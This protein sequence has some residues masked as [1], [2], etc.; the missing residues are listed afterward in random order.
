[1]KSKY[2]VFLLFVFSQSVFFNFSNAATI[3][4]NSTADELNENGNCTFREAVEAANTNQAVDGCSSGDSGLDTINFDSSITGSTITLTLSVVAPPVAHILTTDDLKIEGD[5][6]ITSG[7]ATFIRV[8]IAGN[9]NNPTALELRTVSIDGRVSVNGNLT[10]NG[11]LVT[12]GVENHSS[13][14]GF[15][16]SV[17][18]STVG[19]LGWQH[20]GAISIV[21]ST[22][23]GASSNRLSTAG[24]E[25]GPNTA[26]STIGMITM[27]N[28]I[29]RDHEGIGLSIANAEGPVSIRNSQLL[30]NSRGGL[31]LVNSAAEI[32]NL[33]VE[34]NESMANG[35]AGGISLIN[36]PANQIVALRN[37]QIIGNSINDIA[38]ASGIF[39]NGVAGTVVIENTTIDGNQAPVSSGNPG[40]SAI[41]VV[42]TFKMSGSAVSNNVGGGLT[43]SSPQTVVIENNTFSGNTG[44]AIIG[45][46]AGIGIGLRVDQ[47]SDCTVRNNTIAF[48]I[49]SVGAVISCNPTLLLAN[50]IF[51]NNDLDENTTTFDLNSGPYSGGFNLIGAVQQPDF[52]LTT[53]LLG[54]NADLLPLTNAGGPTL[55]HPL[56]NLSLAINAGDNNLAA[57]LATDQRG[58]GFPRIQQNRVDIGAFETAPANTPL[59]LIGLEVTQVI[60]DWNNSIPLVAAKPTFVRAH[61][62]QTPNLIFKPML[63]GFRN[64]VELPQSPL[65]IDEVSPRA[66]PAT[67]VIE[68]RASNSVPFFVLPPEWIGGTINLLIQ[69]DRSIR[70]RD[71]APPATND[72]A[73]TV[74]F[75]PVRVPKVKFVSLS[76]DDNGTAQTLGQS[77]ADDLALRLKSIFPIHGVTWDH[78]SSM[79]QEPTPPDSDDFNI[80]LVRMLF[81]RAANGCGATCPDLYYGM[82]KGSGGDEF[83][84]AAIGIPSPVA[85][86]FV[87]SDSRAPGRH[88]HSHEFGHNLGLP[89]AVD[90]AL[91][92]VV[93]DGDRLKQGHCDSVADADV[94]DFP[95]LEDVNLIP[96]NNAMI[97]P[98]LGPLSAGENSK[99]YGYDS[100]QD[101]IVDPFRYFAMMSYCASRPIDFWV[102]KNNYQTLKTTINTRFA[103]AEQRVHIGDTPSNYIAFR[104]V[105]DFVS[106]QLTLLPVF[107]LLDIL[108]PE[109][110]PIGDFTLRLSDAQ[111]GII[112]ETAFDMTEV[113]VRGRLKKQGVFLLPVPINPLIKQAEVLLNGN[114][115]ASQQASPNTPVV[116]VLSPDGGETLDSEFVTLRWSATDADG[117]TLNYMVQYSADNGVSWTTLV[118][119]HNQTTLTLDRASLSAANNTGLLRVSASDGFNVGI[120]VSDNTFSVENNPPV[121]LIDSPLPE[122]LFAGTQVMHLIATAND[123]EDGIIDGAAI[124]WSSS[125]DGMLGDGSPLLVDVANLS[126]GEHIITATATDS[127]AGIANATVAITV[128]QTPPDE[129]ADVAVLLQP[130][131][132][133]PISSVRLI[134]QNQGRDPA[135]DVV[136][137]INAEIGLI[138]SINAP[139]GWS[140]TLSTCM[141]DSLAVAEDVTIDLIL[142]SSR[143][144]IFSLEVTIAAQ[145]VDPF[146]LNNIDALVVKPVLLHIDNFDQN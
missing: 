129:F 48:N 89:H 146:M 65:M 17:M 36:V 85:I 6:T 67:N 32:D 92:I 8:L 24:L 1:M 100:L 70:C 80:A 118:V 142:E 87:P 78:V 2:Y 55:T 75:D 37:S 61:F 44:R 11:V 122:R 79:W 90:S 20:Q 77:T 5:V 115:L 30:N 26:G 98:T 117:D 110:P 62:Q 74:R 29:V 39:I 25:L 134:V 41:G 120:A 28:V 119:G 96:G 97:R 106:G 82:V 86:G 40:I 58:P 145:E 56:G 46:N 84:G 23:T 34:N 66:I 112:S 45:P 18:D 121:V 108:P 103:Q 47:G 138:R 38:P 51:T 126:D 105:Y 4:V 116:D 144:S 93:E 57:G 139:A 64:G 10:L 15:A 33:L 88:T 14:G 128:T 143:Q 52:S 3:L 111:G 13:G 136:V 22:I 76:W 124:S 27:N 49:G 63:R 50:N 135:T 114:V 31:T 131:T 42:G 7:S 73:V 125:L 109:V 68:N 123:P 60:Q 91:G 101:I 43:V 94:D 35:Q 140:C 113:E 59:E 72:C 132:L 12:D 54:A 104:G 102:S 81:F 141:T 83:D 127:N 19:Y 16:L 69:A 71:Q 107:H 133:G 95:F 130:Q 21:D 137:D 99:I 53:D 9:F